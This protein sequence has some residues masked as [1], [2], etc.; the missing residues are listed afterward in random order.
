MNN[1]AKKKQKRNKI[2]ARRSQLRQQRK[3]SRADADEAAAQFIESVSYCAVCEAKLS[4]GMEIQRAYVAT[5]ECSI[6]DGCRAPVDPGPGAEFTDYLNETA[7]KLVA[8]MEE[9]GD[10]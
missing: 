6:C 5:H 1:K 3:L 10:V 4:P 8:L 7:Q 9:N 2:L